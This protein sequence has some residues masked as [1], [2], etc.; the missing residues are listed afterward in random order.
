MA[1]DSP[2]LGGYQIKN[3]PEDMQIIAE[4]VQQVNELADG[5]TR[6]RILG[7]RIKATLTWGS[8]WIRSED[9]T[10]LMNVANDTTGQAGTGFG[11][12]SFVPRP[13][14]KPSISFA[15][16]WI[17]KF[18]FSFHEGRHQAYGGTIELIGPTVASSVPNLP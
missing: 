9:L 3:P 16:L 6:Q 15:V 4:A 10:G 7:Y 18:E 13:T 17:N 2:Q 8:N 11:A 12:L 5:S 14:T 1:F